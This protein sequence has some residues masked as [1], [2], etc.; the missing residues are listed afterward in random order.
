MLIVVAV[1]I[2][3]MTMVFRLS[4]IG[5]S[6]WRRNRTIAHLQRVENCLSGYYAAFGS[7]PPVSLHG[8][9]NIFAAVNTH[10]IQS[11]SQENTA[12]WGWTKIGEPAEKRAW[13]QVRAACRAQPVAASF[14]FPDNY[15]GKVK[16]NS[17]MMKMK[18]SSNSS[19][20]RKFWENE[21]TKNRLVAGFDDASS[22]NIGRF[23]SYS[24]ETDWRELQLFRF[25]LMSYLLPRYLVMM[26]GGSEL[27]YTRY[28]QW[29]SNNI[30]PRDPLDDQPLTW[31]RIKELQESDNPYDVAHVA[32]IP[33]QAITARW[34]P[35]LEKT[36]GTNHSGWRIFGIDITSDGDED[37]P[38]SDNEMALDR[39]EET[40]F[41]PGGYDQGGYNN[42][43]V[44]DTVTVY[45]GWA[46]ELY[47]YSPSPHQS[48]TLWSAGPN[49][50]TFPPWVPLDSQALTGNARKL[51]QLWT[52]D[53]IVHMSN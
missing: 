7:Y 46:Q 40:I 16:A 48:Y 5:G 43:Y 52:E 13:N 45:D 15:D 20:F 14:P 17:D 22:A 2:T 31:K 11:D 10:G 28:A 9:R 49:K 21:D 39:M 23:N 18:A 34:M 53:D 27:F 51:V 29:T 6:Q 24:D 19:R 35:N 30:L 36:V 37:I 38:L 4:S 32:N 12:I 26:N 8:S 25:G 47:Y 3:L 33:S 44:L 41:T 42:Q 50:R 1:L